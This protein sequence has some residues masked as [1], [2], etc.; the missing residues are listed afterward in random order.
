MTKRSFHVWSTYHCSDS[1]QREECLRCDAKKARGVNSNWR[2]HF[3]QGGQTCTL[4]I[5][6]SPAERAVM[7]EGRD[8]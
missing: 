2:W 4:Q 1:S 5:D 3:T 7:T 8:G 6:P